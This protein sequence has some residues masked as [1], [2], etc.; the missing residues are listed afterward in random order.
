M[1]FLFIMG[2]SNNICYSS[3]IGIT[4]QMPN[5]Y[6][7]LFL[8]GSGIAGISMSIIKITMAKT[9]KANKSLGVLVFFVFAAIFMVWCKI[10]HMAFIKSE[11]YKT[12]K[13]EQEDN[14]L[15][16]DSEAEYSGFSD[17][18]ESRSLLKKPQRDFAT[19]MEVLRATKFYVLLL[20]VTYIQ[21][22]T[23]FPGIMLMK[24]IACMENDTKV[25]TMN[26]LFSIFFLVGKKL[27][28]YRKYYNKY[29]I[30][31]LVLFRFVLVFFFMAQA[32]TSSI[33]ILNTAWF[34]YLNILLFGLTNGFVTCALFILAPEAVEPSKKEVSGFVSVFGLTSGVLI[35]TLTALPFR[36][37][38]A[39]NLTLPCL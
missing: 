28:Q 16:S 29:S 14:T 33:P 21:M 27:G 11:F 3:I 31:A 25:T 32:V 5:A 38:N 39:N 4:S 23:V 35:G 20:V 1:M 36:T 24:P 2:F 7:T 22:N 17:T 13:A 34:G 6:T 18:R 26:M 10:L 15:Q 9:F 8:I 12:F 30:L 37:L 19:V